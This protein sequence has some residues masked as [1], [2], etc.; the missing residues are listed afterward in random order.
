MTVVIP[1]LHYE[2]FRSFGSRQAD[3][4][5]RGKL[6]RGVSDINGKKL[7]EKLP[8]VRLAGKIGRREE[9]FLSGV[10]ERHTRVNKAKYGACMKTCL[11]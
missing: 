3:G 8:Q 9:N 2:R 4:R 6:R 11:L 7:Y 1:T 5:E 10:S